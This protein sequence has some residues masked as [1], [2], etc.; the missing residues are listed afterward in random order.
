MCIRDRGAGL[1]ERRN[2]VEE[3][4]TEVAAGAECLIVLVKTDGTVRDIGFLVN[5]KQLRFR[6]VLEYVAHA[7]HDDRVADDENALAAV[8]TR[9]HLGRAAQP[10]DDVAPAFSSGRAVVELAEEAA[11]LGLIGVDVLDPEGGEPV[12]NSKLLFAEP[13][14]DHERVG[15]L[16]ESRCL[17]DEAGGVA[18]AEV[19]GGEN[20]VGPIFRRKCAEPVSERNR[21]TL[22]QLG[23][24]SL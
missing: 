13:F 9:D 7:E 11:E 20:D 5:G 4:E 16:V 1:F 19:G 21:L 8:L 23:E 22:P 24:L 14:V 10:E 18:G 12:E 15:I 6:E 3:L 17:D 2:E